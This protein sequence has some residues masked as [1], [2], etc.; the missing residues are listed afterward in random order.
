MDAAMELIWKNSYGATSVEAIC[1][2]AGAKKGSFYHFFASKSDL[3]V[4]ALEANWR[5]KKPRM[6]EIFSASVPPLERLRGYFQHLCQGQRKR[7]AE[8]GSVL[9]CPYCSLGCEI[10]T[11]DRAIGNQ[12]HKILTRNAKYFET[13][14]RDAHAEGSI[15]ASNAKAKARLLV[16]FVQ[17]ALAQARIE[18]N[19]EALRA[20]SAGAL[21]LLGASKA[22][23]K[24]RA[25]RTR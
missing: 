4:A 9:G 5:H 16:A 25:L 13:A 2:E 21:D 6:D 23:A 3:A 12:V 8:C 10:G 11:R 17:G 24:P 22:R 15:E 20:L 1:A 7:H 19:V 18:N 14:I